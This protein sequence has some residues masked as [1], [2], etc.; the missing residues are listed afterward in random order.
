MI[1]RYCELWDE[2]EI[3]ALEPGMDFREP[4]YRREVFH[5]FYQFHLRHR[6]HPGCVYYL[7]PWLRE[8][9]NW[10]T[11]QALWFAF[12]NGNTQNPLTSLVVVEKFPWEDQ[13][14][15]TPRELREWFDHHWK[16]LAFDIDRR[17][18]K[19]DFPASVE[20]YVE[21]VRHYGSQKEMWATSAG[22]PQVWNFIRGALYS[23][24]RM[25]AYSYSEYLRIM[26]IDIEPDSLFLRDLAGSHSL[27]NGLCK[28]L[29]RDDL[30]IG[31]HNPRSPKETYTEEVLAWLEQEGETLLEEARARAS[32]DPKVPDED[33][34]YFTLESAL[35]TYKS[36]HR[37]NRRYP[38]VYND[39][40]RDRILVNEQHWGSRYSQ[41][42]WQAR[43]ECLPPYLRLEDNPNDLG[44]HPTKQ[45]WYLNTGEVVMMG[46]EDPDLR[47][48]YEAFY[49]S[50]IFA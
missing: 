3:S 50:E 13:L 18:Q 14:M 1:G 43:R 46:Y 31:K 12:V 35:C 47:G 41:H 22:F 33:V 11:E 39:M 10:D 8:R 9:F 20:R 26:G 7:M 44:L 25:S 21:A 29:G 34:H 16:R 5:R 6:A 45:N 48:G 23:F 38:N 15:G 42:F 17:Y 28:V 37:P 24:G 2:E 19:K 49:G 30:D 32:S 27:R 36:W 40:L 4:S